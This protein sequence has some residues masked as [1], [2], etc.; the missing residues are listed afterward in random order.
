MTNGDIDVFAQTD[1]IAAILSQHGLPPETLVLVDNIQSWCQEQ[2][3]DEP[4]P[5]RA[6]KTL[7]LSGPPHALILLPKV[8]SRDMVESVTG[9]VMFH[10]F[11]VIPRLNQ[12]DRDFLRHLVLHEIAHILSRDRGESECDVWASKEL[13]KL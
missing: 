2:G 9:A 3:I 11:E 10:D 13:G 12:N 5:F 4:N 8:I 7:F 6:A 1:D